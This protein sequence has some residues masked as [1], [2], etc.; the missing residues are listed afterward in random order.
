M[1]DR[2]YLDGPS[3]TTAGRRHRPGPF[4]DDR[5]GGRTVESLHRG[6]PWLPLEPTDRDELYT[7][8]L[9]T[10]REEAEDLKNSSRSL[11]VGT[12]GRAL[13]GVQ[14][15]GILRAGRGKRPAG[16]FPSSPVS[17]RPAIG[18][19][20]REPQKR[21]FPGIDQIAWPPSF[22]IPDYF[23]VYPRPSRQ[24]PIALW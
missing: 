16:V 14:A 8:T 11:P 7:G 23:T 10:Q 18:G 2:I 5:G 22:Q 9:K 3:G 24:A 13:E 19:R 17:H 1:A 6:P 15:A 21:E 12:Q 20:R 4:H